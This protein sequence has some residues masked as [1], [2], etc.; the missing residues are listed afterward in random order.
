MRRKERNTK[1]RKRMLHLVNRTCSRVLLRRLR[2][3]LLTK[4]I[5]M[6]MDRKRQRNQKM[7]QSSQ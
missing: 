6:E 7:T 1:K 3:R 4:M 2:G 5:F